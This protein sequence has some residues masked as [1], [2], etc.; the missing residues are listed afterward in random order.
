MAKKQITIK[1]PYVLGYIRDEYAGCYRVHKFGNA[2]DQFDMIPF[3]VFEPMMPVLERIFGSD[4]K[5]ISN[6]ID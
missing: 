3:A 1:P 4:F 5:D 2:G 6:D